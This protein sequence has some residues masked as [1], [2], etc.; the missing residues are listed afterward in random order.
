MKLI[1]TTHPFFRPRWI[2]VL[3]VAFCLAWASFEVSIGQPLWA[4][5]SG[6]IGAYCAWVLLITYTPD[7][8][9]DDTDG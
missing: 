5:L 9:E 2:R 8:P 6:A 1:D 7:P 3:I 4:L